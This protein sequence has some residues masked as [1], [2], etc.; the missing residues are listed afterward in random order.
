VPEQNHY[1][2]GQA[3]LEGVMMRGR[4]HWAIAVRQPDQTMH[5]EAHPID[6]IAKRFPILAKPGLRGV[7]ALGQ[8]LA[9]GVKALT[10]SANHAVEEEER[11]TRG[12]MAGSM[13]LAFSLFTLVFIV[14]PYLG[15]RLFRKGLP[16]SL[17]RNL[18]EGVVRILLFLIYLVA[19]GRMKE[20][21]RVFQYHGA[22]HK[23]IAAYE[24]GDPLEPEA[25]DKYST[26]HVRCGTKFLLIVM[27]LTIL[28]YTAFGSRGLLAGIL[29]RIVAIPVIAG[30]SYEL[31]RLGAR[32]TRS[33][34]MRALM[35]PG[36]WL[37]KITTRQ[38]DRGQ[39]EVAITAFKEVLRQEGTLSSA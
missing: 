6:S 37:Q 2:G 30:L 7:I 31:L 36:L 33:G 4:D 20:I 11:L 9:I 25:V 17:V 12:Q 24:H 14:G 10:V 1:Y 16:S 5:V 35:A 28:V 19:I 32:Y 3:V 27:V 34:V 8:A 39:I 13:V 26:L 29:F 21:R 38:P 23:T 15:F 18:L 22:E